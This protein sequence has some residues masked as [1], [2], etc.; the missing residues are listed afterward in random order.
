MPVSDR[1]ERGGDGGWEA[2]VRWWWWS[3]PADGR[4]K[5]EE[6]REKQAEREKSVCGWMTSFLRHAIR[7]SA[8]HCILCSVPAVSAHF[9]GFLAHYRGALR[10]VLGEAG[11]VAG[12]KLGGCR[13]YEN[14]RRLRH[15][16]I[17]RLNRL[18]PA[19]NA[20]AAATAQRRIQP[21]REGAN[22]GERRGRSGAHQ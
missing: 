4:R 9:A 19:K 17:Y 20:L 22:V 1:S 10:E 14:C 7:C 11:C 3:G 6:R 21:K 12:R 18:L 8:L 5:K 15:T 2:G 16:R 13:R